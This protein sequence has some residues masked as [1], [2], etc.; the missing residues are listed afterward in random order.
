MSCI[1]TRFIIVIRFYLKISRLAIELANIM[2]LNF[3]ILHSKYLHIKMWQLFIEDWEIRLLVYDWHKQ[4]GMNTARLLVQ[5]ILPTFSHL[6][7]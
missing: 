6:L 2:R 5:L 3:S 1:D 7:I 4:I